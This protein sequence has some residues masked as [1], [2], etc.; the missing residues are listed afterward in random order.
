MLL[1][2]GLRCGEI[3]AL[4]PKDVDFKRKTLSVSKTVSRDIYS[5]PVI[6]DRTK[7]FA[8]TRIIPLEKDV[9]ECFRKAIAEMKKNNNNLIFTQA[10]GNIMRVS[11]VNTQFKR[12][13][14][15]LKFKNECNF[16]MLRHTYA[17]RCIEAGMP[18]AVL[19]KLLGHTD[20]STTINTYTTIFSRYT[21]SELKKV[22]NYKKNKNLEIEV[23]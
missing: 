14:K 20:I 18:A 4:T 3:L 17:T 19:Q 5:N 16:H 6:Y 15:K 8:G 10:N 1:I 22:V 9:E 13:C 7:T 11:N 21:K 23:L 12:I 2:L